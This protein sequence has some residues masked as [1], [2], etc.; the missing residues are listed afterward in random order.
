MSDKNIFKQSFLINKEERALRFKQ[1]PKLIW[2]TGL[3]G[4]GKSTLSCSLEKSLFCRGFSTYSLDGDNIRLGLCKD[5]GFSTL[6]RIENIRRVAEVS[7]LM[8]DAGL[9]VLSSF[10]SPL[11]QQR[12]LIRSIVGS[13]N[14]IEVYV[15]TSLEECEKRDIKG[16][17]K[18]ARSGLIENFTGIS[19]I[20]EPPVNPEIKID[21]TN[22]SI[23]A[24][25]KELLNQILTKINA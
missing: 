4:S 1:T 14:V 23:D 3:S 25:V 11:I 18:K 2:F 24:S 10:I 12:E 22:I 19:S 6:N 20:Y 21:T 8:L 5:L 13:E 7:N 9:I 17:Y 16:L 15:S